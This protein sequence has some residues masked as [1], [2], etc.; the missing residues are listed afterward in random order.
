MFSSEP[1]QGLCESV[2]R[3]CLPGVII[4]ILSVRAYPH[5]NYMERSSELRD[6]AVNFH[7]KGIH[8]SSHTTTTATMKPSTH[9][10]D[11]STKAIIFYCSLYLILKTFTG[12]KFSIKLTVEVVGSWDTVQ[13]DF[14]LF[15]FFASL[16][17]SFVLLMDMA[18]KNW[19]SSGP[20]E[21]NPG[22]L[23]W[24]MFGTSACSSNQA[25]TSVTFP[26][27]FCELSQLG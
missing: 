16:N 2:P 22:E 7:D 11:I 13:Q 12:Y 1:H 8:R 9:L 15:L 21:G 17:L 6:S 3:S 20:R 19:Y 24:G 25:P 23:C 18:P 26:I 14:H 10:G 5:D 4:T 27:S